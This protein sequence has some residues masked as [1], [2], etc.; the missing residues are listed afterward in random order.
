[1]T[2]ASEL[3]ATIRSLPPLPAGIS[4]LLSLDQAEP[5]YLEKASGIIRTDP[6]LVAQIIKIANSAVYTGQDR[7]D[8]LERALLRVGVRTAVNALV[9]AHLQRA[10]SPQEERLQALWVTNLLAAILARSI[11]EAQPALEIVPETAYT[12]GLLHDVGRLVMILM[13]HDASALRTSVHPVRELHQLEKESFPHDHQMA[14]RLLAHGWHFPRTLALVIATHHEPSE[15]RAGHPPIVERLVNLMALVDHVGMNILAGLP[16]CEDLEGGVAA[17]L[18]EEDVAALS[19]DLGLSRKDV[20]Q[21]LAP[22]LSELKLHARGMGI[23][24]DQGI[25]STR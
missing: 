25:A 6:A 20:L 10:F 17:T 8:T 4:R 16:E 15:R 24:L 2:G 3:L 14:G 9:S 19:D 1:M 11:A 13:D 12:F 21:I 5:S 18:Q 7:V 22:S 23:P